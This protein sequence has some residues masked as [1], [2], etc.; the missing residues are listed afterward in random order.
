M[1]G[2]KLKCIRSFYENKY[3]INL[4]TSGDEYVIEKVKG[5]LIYIR[6][7][8]SNIKEFGTSNTSKNIL[9]D[10]FILK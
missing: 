8:N 5:N 6:D 4:Y 2:K 1:K 9:K 7:N 3:S 10:Y